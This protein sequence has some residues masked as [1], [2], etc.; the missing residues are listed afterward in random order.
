MQV[1]ALSQAIKDKERVNVFVDGEFFLALDK[2]TIIQE[3][4]FVGKELDGTYIQKLKDIDSYNLVFRKVLNWAISRPRST[5]EV[6]EKINKIILNRKSK[7]FNSNLNKEDLNKFVINKLANNNIN[8]FEYATWW[9]KNRVAQGKYGEKR[10]AAE[11]SSKGINSST[12][13]QLLSEHYPKDNSVVIKLLS[14][15]FGVTSIKQ[16]PD[17]KIRAKAY[18]YIVSKGFRAL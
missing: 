18:R 17:Q 6:K 9:V 8:D 12:I 1:T 10:I 14:K 13:R 11:L 7:S 2:N 15:K 16:I 3:K 4:L 5:F